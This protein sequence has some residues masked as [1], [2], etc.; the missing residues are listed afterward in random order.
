MKL[1]IALLRRKEL[2]GKLDR[3]RPINDRE[4]YMAKVSRQKISDDVDEARIIVPII[5]FDQVNGAYDHYAKQLRLVDAA[6]QQT[7]WTTEVENIN[8]SDVM[9]D[10]VDKTE[11][12]QFFEILRTMGV[13][14]RVRTVP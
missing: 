1:A 9:N 12:K 2:Q 6:I 3:I 14:A 10:Y 8:E 4:L 5:T 11:I 7:N 13:G